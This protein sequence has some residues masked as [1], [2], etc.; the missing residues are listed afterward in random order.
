MKRLR[1]KTIAATVGGG[2][3]DEELPFVDSGMTC[4]GPVCMGR[5]YGCCPQ[6]RFCVGAYETDYF[7]SA[8]SYIFFNGTCGVTTYQCI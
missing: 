4:A 2:L 5:T 1:I 6:G 8:V 3:G 7:C